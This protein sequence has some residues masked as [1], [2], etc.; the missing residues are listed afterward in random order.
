MNAAFDVGAG[1]PNGKMQRALHEE[2]CGC[3]FTSAK[4]EISPTPAC[5]A[6]G[7]SLRADFARTEE[8]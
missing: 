1:K 4:Y 3:I 6:G 2:A 8:Q 5:G 7:L